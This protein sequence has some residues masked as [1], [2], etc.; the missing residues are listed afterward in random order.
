MLHKLVFLAYIRPMFG[1][2]GNRDDPPPPGQFC[3]LFLAL[4]FILA[5]CAAGAAPPTDKPR[6]LPESKKFTR[7]GDLSDVIGEMPGTRSTGG[8]IIYIGVYGGDVPSWDGARYFNPKEWAPYRDVDG[9]KEFNEV[10]F[11]ESVMHVVAIQ[12]SRLFSN[13]ITLMIRGDSDVLA[14]VI[15]YLYSPGDKIYLV[16][17]S[18]GGAVIAQAAFELQ[19]R[20]IPVAMLAQIEGFLSYVTV[21]GN[22]TRAFNFYVPSRLALCPGRQRLEPESPAVTQVSNVAIDDPWGPF[23]GPC[24]AHRNIDSDPRV[25]K[26]ILQYVMDSAQ[27]AK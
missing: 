14:D 17:H 20:G 12:I 3:F 19:R 7:P 23:N 5:S 21:P 13:A 16:G 18:Q 24:A 27:E 22:V 10:A 1:K 25:R 2:N 15:V 9:E 4:S 6:P 26:T 11:H 8:R